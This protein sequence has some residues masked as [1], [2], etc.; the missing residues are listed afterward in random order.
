MTLVSSKSGRSLMGLAAGAANE[1]AT[2]E[3]AN[4]M[5]EKATMFNAKV[6]SAKVVDKKECLVLLDYCLR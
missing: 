2:A 4:A 1:P 3:S 6:V 5:W